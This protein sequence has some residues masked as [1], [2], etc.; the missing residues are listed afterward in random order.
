MLMLHCS[1]IWL[2]NIYVDATILAPL[3]KEVF[4][5]LKWMRNDS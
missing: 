4:E 1:M 5:V 2:N 3:K